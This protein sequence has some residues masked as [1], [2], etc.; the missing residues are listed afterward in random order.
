MRTI[1]ILLKKIIDKIYYNRYYVWREILIRK[2]FPWIKNVWDYKKLNNF[3]KETDISSVNRLIEIVWD[4]YRWE[5]SRLSLEWKFSTIERY[6]W[7]LDFAQA[8]EDYQMLLLKE[9]EEN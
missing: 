7:L 5:V 4:F 9:S 6:Q 1:I 2:I 8:L 3:L